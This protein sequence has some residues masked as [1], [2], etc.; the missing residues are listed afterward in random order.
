[1]DGG[2]KACCNE[3]LQW[4]RCIEDYL[5]LLC[6]LEQSSE[7]TEPPPIAGSIRMAPHGSISDP[8]LVED[9]ARHVTDQ[10]RCTCAWLFA[11]RDCFH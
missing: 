10:W 1:M 7:G 4:E 8:R 9:S 3:P 6:A 11:W 5:K 2:S